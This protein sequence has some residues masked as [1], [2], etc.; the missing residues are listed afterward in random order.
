MGAN[1]LLGLSHGEKVHLR[2]LSVRSLHLVCRRTLSYS[3]NKVCIRS[4]VPSKFR[5]KFCL[6]VKQGKYLG[7][8]SP[9]PYNYLLPMGHFSCTVSFDNWHFLVLSF[10][11][12]GNRGRSCAHHALMMRSSCAHHALMG[13]YIFNGKSV[14][15]S[16]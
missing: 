5:C 1:E 12:V 13:R 14:V 2:R 3:T 8:I 15:T 10:Y 6:R 16:R 11:H 9:C 7:S 4:F